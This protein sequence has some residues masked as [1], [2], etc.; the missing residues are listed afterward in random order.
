V[1]LADQVKNLDWR[2]RHVVKK[3]RAHDRT[4][5]QALGKLRA[6]LDWRGGE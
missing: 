2:A 5:L 6:L 3:G 1:V 4:V